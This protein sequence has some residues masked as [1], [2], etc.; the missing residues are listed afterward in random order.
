MKQEIATQGC[1]LEIRLYMLEEMLNKKLKVTSVKQ[2][3]EGTARLRTEPLYTIGPF[4]G[5]HTIV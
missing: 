5:M 3:A 1:Y 2:S 4:K